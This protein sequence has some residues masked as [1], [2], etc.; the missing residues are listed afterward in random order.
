[1]Q[2]KK[3][4]VTGLL[5]L[6]LP[7]GTAAKCVE[8]S[9]PTAPGGEGGFPKPITTPG[10]GAPHKQP[11]ANA[12]KELR[13]PAPPPADPGP[14]QDPKQ[15]VF[16]LIATGPDERSG[17][18]VEFTIGGS[19]QRIE[20]PLPIKRGDGQFYTTW[21]KTIS[22]IPGNTIGFSFYPNN[23]EHTWSM[24]TLYHDGQIEDYQIAP[25]YGCSVGFKA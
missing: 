7:F 25:S 15:A 10:N 19:P 17:S 14:Y 18:Y 9:S 4:F 1:M 22:V 23:P 12:P 5:V 8:S 3:L 13:Q 20:L 11:N 2:L 24:C 6:A 16:V 21:E